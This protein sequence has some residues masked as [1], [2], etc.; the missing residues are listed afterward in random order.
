MKIINIKL[1][2]VLKFSESEKFS[3][4]YVSARAKVHKFNQETERQAFTEDLSKEL[5]E[6]FGEF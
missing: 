3:I 6:I 2:R 5:Q 1:E 4:L